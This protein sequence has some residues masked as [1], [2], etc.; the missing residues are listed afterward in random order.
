MLDSLLF[1]AV[2]PAVTQLCPVNQLVLH[3][4]TPLGPEGRDL[5]LSRCP[6]VASNHHGTVE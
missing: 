1:W 3:H 2:T 5:L 4:H 6:Q